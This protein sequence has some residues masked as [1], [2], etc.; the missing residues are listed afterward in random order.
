MKTISLQVRVPA[1]LRKEADEILDSVGLDMSTAMRIYLKKIVSLRGI[2]F[3]LTA[4]KIEAPEVLEQV[5][6][7]DEI[8][9]KLNAIDSLWKE[10]KGK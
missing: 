3:S 4:E 10:I 5:E 8:Q 1:S 9:D 2:P 7:D 6:V